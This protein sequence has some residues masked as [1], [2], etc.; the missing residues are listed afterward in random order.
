[1]SKLLKNK[2]INKAFKIRDEI[3]N[4]RINPLRQEMYELHE[5][6]TI[7]EENLMQLEEVYAQ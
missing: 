2:R 1:M 6:K 4:F 3:I 7:F 5:S